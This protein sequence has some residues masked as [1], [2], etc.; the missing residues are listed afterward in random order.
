MSHARDLFFGRE[1]LVGDLHLPDGNGP[2][3]AV[4]LLD[5]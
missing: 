3:P 4:V 1:T 2:F 5:R